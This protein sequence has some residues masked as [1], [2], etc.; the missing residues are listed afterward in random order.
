MDGAQGDK[1]QHLE[2]PAKIDA[3]AQPPDVGECRARH[4]RH[5]ERLDAAQ[6]PRA[7]LAIQLLHRAHIRAVGETAIRD[8]TEDLMI[9]DEAQAASVHEAAV[10]CPIK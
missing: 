5:R 3:A 6:L 7:H 2:V 10:R 4:P 1:R 9:T 8:Q